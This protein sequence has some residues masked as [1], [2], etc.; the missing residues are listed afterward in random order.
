ME[1]GHTSTLTSQ[2]R[3]NNESTSK[4]VLKDLACL[5]VW[6]EDVFK[7]ILFMLIIV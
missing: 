1:R 6:L 4:W 7:A 2:L 5:D 3:E